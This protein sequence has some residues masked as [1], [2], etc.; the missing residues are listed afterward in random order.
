MEAPGKGF[1]FAGTKN[2]PADRIESRFFPNKSG[3]PPK[4]VL[5][6]YRGSVIMKN[7]LLG[8]FWKLIK[9]WPILNGF[10]SL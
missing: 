5:P 2:I 8:S 1:S 10:F 6:I 9:F 3:D 7:N 4:F